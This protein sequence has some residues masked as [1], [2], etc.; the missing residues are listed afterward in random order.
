MM[1]LLFLVI[2]TF[3]IGCPTP[4]SVQSGSSYPL[5]TCIVTDNVLGSMGTPITRTYKGQDVK[6]CCKP[7]L[8]KL[9]DKVSGKASY[10]P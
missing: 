7:Y 3:A 4:S 5:N 6:F 1:K 8:K 10:K 9:K 2:L